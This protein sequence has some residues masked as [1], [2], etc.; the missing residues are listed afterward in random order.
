MLSPRI[1]PQP[2]ATNASERIVKIYDHHG[3]LSENS[4]NVQ[5]KY[6]AAIVS[7]VHVHLD[8]DNRLEVVLV[9]GKTSLVKNP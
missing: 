1:K 5:H 8:H 2:I 9:R 7:T 6:Y 4:R 3:L